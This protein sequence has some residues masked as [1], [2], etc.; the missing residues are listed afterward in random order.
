MP[1]TAGGEAMTISV[2][3][4][5]NAAPDRPAGCSAAVL[6]LV[7]V[8]VIT[9][10]PPLTMLAGVKDLAMVGRA[11]TVSDPV[12]SCPF[13]PLSLVFRSPISIRLVNLP[14]AAVCTVAVRRQVLKDGKLP[15]A[16]RMLLP[17]MV[18]V[19]PAQVVPAVPA[20]SVMPAGMSSISA[21]GAAPV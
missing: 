12:T 5:E 19:P 20:I 9:E 21:N 14:A 3:V 16:S 13:D 8:K 1:P 10:T 6:G 4:S 15:A 18:A 17:T 11:T 7:S 2:S